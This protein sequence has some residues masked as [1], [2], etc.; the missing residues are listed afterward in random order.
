MA[1]EADE[2]GGV[3]TIAIGGLRLRLGLGIGLGIGH[4]ELEQ[5]PVGAA[6]VQM[7]FPAGIALGNNCIFGKVATTSMNICCTELLRTSPTT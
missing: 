6:S 7:L 2:A 5:L 4:L 3:R 1:L